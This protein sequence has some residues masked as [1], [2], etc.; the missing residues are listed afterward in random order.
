MP[1]T[2]HKRELQYSS[3][4]PWEEKDD[5]LKEE[6]ELKAKAK[7]ERTK[8]KS[9]DFGQVFYGRDLN[10]YKEVV[11]WPMFILLIIELGVR[12]MQTKYLYLWN[13]EIF[14]YTIYLSR[15]ILFSY[16]GISAVKRYKATKTQA[17]FAAAL[18][19]F[20]TGFLLAI[21]QLFWYFELWAFFNLIG[22]P[23]L[24]MATGVVITWF[25]TIFIRK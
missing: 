18:G 15:I 17:V 2:Q 19:G 23:L 12:V 16:L 5:S 25:I 22:Q 8:K 14:S 24:M 7:S 13:A 9:N 4:F 20:V 10:W 1:P 3:G 6:M 11:L 21:F